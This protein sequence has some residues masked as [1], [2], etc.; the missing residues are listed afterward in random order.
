VH[1]HRLH[2]GERERE[3]MVQMIIERRARLAIAARSVI[4]RNVQREGEFC[5]RSENPNIWTQCARH[6]G[7]E[8]V[9]RFHL[10]PANV[11]FWFATNQPPLFAFAS[12]PIS[13]VCQS[14]NR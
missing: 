7:R 3:S 9:S 13:P 10:R 8:S 4:N 12:L 11:P 5:V 1:T 6:S 2:E 14:D